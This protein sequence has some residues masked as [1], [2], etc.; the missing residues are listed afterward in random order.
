MKSLLDYIGQTAVRQ[1]LFDLLLVARQTAE[2][3]PPLLLSGPVDM[4]KS[5]LSTLIAVEL[6]APFRSINASEAERPG[7]VSAVLTNLE[8]GSVLLVRE[9]DRLS[10]TILDMLVRAISRFEFQLVIGKGPIARTMQLPLPPFSPI[11][12]TARP[13]EVHRSLM[14]HCVLLDFDPYSQDEMTKIV[15]NLAEAEQLTIDQKTAGMV[16]MHS[17]GRPGEAEHL[18]LRL[19]R[20]AVHPPGELPE[21]SVLDAFKR[22]GYVRSKPTLTELTEKLKAM[23]AIDFERYVAAIFRQSGFVVETT[24]ATGDHGIDLVVRRDGQRGVIQCKRWDSAVGE[25][26]IREFLGSVVGAQAEIGYYVTTNT[27]TQ[28]ARSF[29]E[30]KPLRLIDLDELVFLALGSSAL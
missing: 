15:M 20:F 16:A 22:L 8:K 9:A 29:A 3:L 10:Q 4:G 21:Q 18:L 25:P 5:F 14:R 12:T 28:R 24:K 23:S 6:D 26:P 7:D 30:D 17:Q 13:S 27:F 19:N 2:T 1:R 11:F